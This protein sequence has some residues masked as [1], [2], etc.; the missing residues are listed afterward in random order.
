MCQKEF[1]ERLSPTARQRFFERIAFIWVFSE[2]NV[3]QLASAS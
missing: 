1:S 2:V 3:T